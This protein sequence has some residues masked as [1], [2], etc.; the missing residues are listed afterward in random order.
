[1]T[2]F[3]IGDRVQYFT[4]GQLYEHGEVADID[5]NLDTSWSLYYVQWDQDDGGTEP[6]FDYELRL[7]ED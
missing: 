6:C 3:E 2:Q 4:G 5:T 1:M 7:E